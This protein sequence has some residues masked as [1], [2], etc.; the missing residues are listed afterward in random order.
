[1]AET[2]PTTQDTQD[3][4]PLVPFNIY[5]AQ[6]TNQF[7]PSENTST[8]HLFDEFINSFNESYAKAL[9]SSYSSANGISGVTIYDLF[10]STQSA[11]GLDI[12]YRANV[13]EQ[14]KNSGLLRAY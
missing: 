6:V 7:N 4:S 14:I 2:P 13:L 3:N 1:M 11:V 9:S 10:K 5:L 8:T 12:K